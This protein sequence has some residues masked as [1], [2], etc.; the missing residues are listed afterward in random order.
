[1]RTILAILTLAVSL[2]ANAGALVDVAWLQKNLGR[3]DVIL[4]DTS[5][6]RNYAAGHIP[7]A[8]NADL[9]GARFHRAAAP[10]IEQR[11]QAWGISPGKRVVLYDAG[12]SNMATWLFFEL[13]HYGFA[14]QD[15][16]I[17]D[18]GLAKWKAS[19]GEVTKDPAPA[20]AKGTFR[21]TQ[22]REEVRSRLPEFMQASGDRGTNV[23]VEALGPE[24]HYGDTRFFNIAGHIPHA[25]M[26][27]K[28]DFYN[29]DKTFKSPEEIRRMASFLGIKQD[30]MVH[31]HCGGGVA[32]TVPFFAL[33]FIAGH[34]KVKVYKES[35]FEWVRDDRG[36]PIWTYDAPSMKREAAWVNGWNNKMIRMYGVAT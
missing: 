27:P 11:L 29:A 15:L 34:E 13:Y 18:G 30:Q 10:E 3:D 22:A 28:E 23:L 33:R 20:P 12:A 36:L 1:M 7:G 19:G 35:Q 6:P 24:Y 32:A 5:S 9:Y 26:W 25:V 21:V 16:M 17:L 31:S 8:I 4:I 2:L 14:E